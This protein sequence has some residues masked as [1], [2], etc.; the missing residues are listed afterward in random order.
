LSA[1]RNAADGLG[2]V[3]LLDPAAVVAALLRVAVARQLA[4]LLADRGQLLAQQVLALALLHALPDVGRDLLADLHLGEVGLGLLEQEL[5]ALDD[6][7]GLEQAQ[8]LGGLDPGGVAG[9]VRQ[10]R[11]VGHLLDGVDHLIGL[12]LLQDRRQ[13]V[14]VLAGQLARPAGR[15]GGVEQLGL[16]PQRGP[17]AGDAGADAGA[18]GGAQHGGGLAAGQATDLG[19]LGHGADDTGAAVDAGDEEEAEGFAGVAVQVAQVGRSAAPARGAGGIDR[20]L[21]LVGHLDGQDHAG[22]D[23]G[24]IEE[25]DGKRRRHAPVNVITRLHLPDLSLPDSIRPGRTR[26]PARPTVRGGVRRGRGRG[27]P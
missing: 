25:Q 22:Q 8:L 9:G 19:D 27:R 10:L 23:H 24:V 17:G 26:R 2:Q 20:G 14:L 13:D 16:D 11:R 1:S 4:E 7:D 15:G 21:R 6:V 3:G 18:G 5:Q 12:A